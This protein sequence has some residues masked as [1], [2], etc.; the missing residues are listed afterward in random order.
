MT[1]NK[2]VMASQARVIHKYK[3]LKH[4]VLKCNA[5]IC[6]NKKILDLN[7]VPKYISRTSSGSNFTQKNL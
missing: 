7:L 4:K 1:Q 6:F 5:S 3:N 2:S